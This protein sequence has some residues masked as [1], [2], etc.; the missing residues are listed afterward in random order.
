[1]YFAADDPKH[2]NRSH[3]MFVLEGPPAHENPVNPDA[4]KFAGRLGGMPHDQWAI[5]GTVITLHGAMCFVYSGWPFGN[6]ADESKQ[7][8]YI[9]EMASPTECVGQPTRISTPDYQW[10]Y[11]GKSGINE[12]PQFL[13]SPDGRWCGIAYSCAG[14]WTSEYKM[15]VLQYVGGNPVHASSWQKWNTPLLTCSRDG[16]PPYGPGHGNF[17]SVNG[18]GGQE[19][20]GVFHATDARTGWEGRKARLMRVGWNERGPHMGKGECG[21]CC[22]DVN[23]FLHGPPPGAVPPPGHGHHGGGG[24]SDV[25]AELMGLVGEGKKLFKKF[26]K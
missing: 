26:L 22:S 25:K 24:S 2:G 1:V 9:I 3:R 18:P 17:V 12:G 4:W 19:V 7:E 6:H 11:S 16:S 21:V 15:A 8:L 23:W 13:C 20:W 14:S 10:E 5:D